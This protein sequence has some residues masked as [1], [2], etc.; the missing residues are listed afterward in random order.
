MWQWFVITVPSTT[1]S[2]G[3]VQSFDFPNI[4]KSAQVAGMIVSEHINKR[5]NGTNDCCISHTA[6]VIRDSKMLVG[7]WSIETYMS[8]T[9]TAWLVDH[10]W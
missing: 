9:F 7:A 5:F 4:K 2:S 6:A 1:Y 10:L 3:N 8:F